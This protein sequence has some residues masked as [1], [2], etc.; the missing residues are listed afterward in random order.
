MTIFVTSR[1]LS[2]V[3]SGHAAGRSATRTAPHKPGTAC[4]RGPVRM[5]DE[6]RPRVLVIDDDPTVRE[7]VS[8][9][10]ASFG[11]DCE[12]AADGVSGLARFDE[13]RWHLVLTDLAM[14]EMNGWEVAAAIRRRAPTTPIL[15]ITG[16][17]GPEVMQ[18]AAERGLRVVPKP[19]R[20]ALLR[21]AVATALQTNPSCQGSIASQG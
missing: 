4:I 2:R 18:R 15:L 14:P 6:H 12:T 17:I 10:L 3:P 20:S 13:G 8:Y 7:V 9:L 1:K 5:V 19:F 21:V 11:Y 16:L